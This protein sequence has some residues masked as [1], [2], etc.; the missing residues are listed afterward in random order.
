M[1]EKK[2]VVPDTLDGIL[3][4]YEDVIYDASHITDSPPKVLSVGPRLDIALGGGVPEGSMVILTGPEKIGK[5]TTALSL[6]A[7]AQKASTEEIKRRVFFGNVE[8]RLKKRDIEGI[9]DISVD[10]E[11]FK[12][13]GSVKGHILSGEE[14]LAAFDTLVH[15]VPHGI[16]IID[17]FSM[18]TAKDELQGSLTDVQVMA[19][20]KTIA[21]FC[22]RV[23]N[24]LP[25][26]RFTIVGITHMM[27]NVAKFGNAPSKVEKTAGALKYQADVKLHA[28]HSTPVMKGETQI[29]QTV[30]WKVVTSALRGTGTKTQS[31]IKY[32]R[33]IWREYEMVEIAKELGIITGKGSWFTL[34]DGNKIQGQPNVADF[35]EMDEVAFADLEQQVYEM[36]GFRDESN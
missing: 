5:T 2:E 31:T 3:K 23:S 9:A 34:P 10:P 14:Y 20:Q 35:Y 28:S 26:N 33:G 29:G 30:H 6:C 15:A 17:S 4:K 21:K 7:N 16:G 1:S 12:I 13:I 19:I 32:G 8:G 22:R 25:I 11:L 27:A 18:L 36:L 24:V